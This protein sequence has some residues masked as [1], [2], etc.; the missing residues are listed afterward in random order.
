MLIT[1]SLFEFIVV[2]VTL[3]IRPVIA[4]NDLACLID[5]NQHYLLIAVALMLLGGIWDTNIKGSMA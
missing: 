1:F 2:S 3:V 4:K 5:Y